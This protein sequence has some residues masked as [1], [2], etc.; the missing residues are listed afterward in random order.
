MMLRKPTT[1]FKHKDDVMKNPRYIV[2]FWKWS[3][4]VKVGVILAILTTLIFA[5]FGLR[6]YD[7]LR[8]QKI[9]DLNL[10][11]D[12]TLAKLTQ[13][14]IRS[15]W[16]FDQDLGAKMI[17]AEMQEEAIYA[18][19]VK[20]DNGH[21]FVG[22]SR[23]SDWQIVDSQEEIVGDFIIRQ[24][25]LVSSEG[26]IG[27]VGLYLTQQFLHEDLQ[28]AVRDLLMT[29]GVLGMSVFLVVVITLRFL[30]IRPL[31]QILDMAQTIAAGE[32]SQEIRIRQQD[33]IGKLADAIR[34]MK[35]KI[36]TVVD[37][38]ERLTLAVQ[39]GHLATR[40]DPTGYTGS[41]RTLVLGINNVIDAFVAPI[42]VTTHSLQQMAGGDLPDRMTQTYQGDF[43]EIQDS[44]N[45][46]ITNLKTFAANIRIAADQ[47]AFSSQDLS[48]NA[49]H[50]SQSASEQ[51]AAA[52]E[53]SATMEQ[54]TANITQ[55]ADN[56]RQ[57]EKIAVK[58]ARKAREGGQAVTEAVQAMQKIAKK[59]SI[60]EDIAS[61]THMLSLNATI[62]AA[63]AQDYG[64]G[65]AVVAA[66]VRSLAQ[67]SQEAAEE[68]NDLSNSGVRLA[69][70]A[71]EL[72]YTLV[73][74]IEDTARLVQEIS[75][76]SSEQSTG[77]KHVNHA[78]QQL[79]QSI[80]HNMTASEETAST[81]EQ[82]AQQAEQLRQMI[83]FFK[84]ANPPRQSASLTKPVSG[85]N[86]GIPK[87]PH[88]DFP[89]DFRIDKKQLRGKH[90]PD[91]P[92]AVKS[93]DD[94]DGEFEQL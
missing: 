74:D 67:R 14:L 29:V 20:N 45:V 52:E 34:S 92:D 17:L 51:A 6:Q 11:A 18:I 7:A 61:Q 81:A 25:E 27:A 33:E 88:I 39:E 90:H 89:R 23:N 70:T 94:L 46:M 93:G 21:L 4:Q 63:K 56:A 28:R 41:W 31:N 36:M 91:L 87:Q 53:V 43:N 71:S 12:V 73:P 59:I 65:F 69:E 64:K 32:F 19:V 85:S 5:G 76:A 62:E 49:E 10:L 86:P 47:M 55:N 78:I 77:A 8:S 68:I 58:A 80:Q 72:L 84:T 48:A 40:G 3:V 54:M 37:E 50:L 35:Q 1:Q 79:D 57:T 30:V 26:K 2:H 22:K 42:R 83:A 24:Q 15:L 38:I 16:D 13:N 60:I 75:A 9:E 82:L 66:E 44:L